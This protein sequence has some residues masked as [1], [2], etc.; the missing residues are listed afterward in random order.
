VIKGKLRVAQH[1]W[2][3]ANPGKIIIHVLASLANAAYQA[4]FTVRNIKAAFA[5]PSILPF[6]RLAIGD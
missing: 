1:D 4:S 6:S 3:T 5:K 2:T